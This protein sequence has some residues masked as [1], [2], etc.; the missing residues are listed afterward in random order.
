[1]QIKNYFFVWLIGNY[2]LVLRYV[3]KPEEVFDSL[4]LANT[5]ETKRIARWNLND[6]RGKFSH[7]SCFYRTLLV[8]LPEAIQKMVIHS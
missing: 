6:A 5:L 3:K 1:M 8:Y 4:N 2:E 7:P